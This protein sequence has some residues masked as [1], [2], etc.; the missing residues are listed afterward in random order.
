MVRANMGIMCLPEWT[1]KPFKL[2]EDLVFKR[3]GKHG[4]KRAH[5]LV[6]KKEQRKLGYYDNFISNFLEDFSNLI[7]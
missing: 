5:Y 2:S 3:I 1:L 6:I 7:D 4:L